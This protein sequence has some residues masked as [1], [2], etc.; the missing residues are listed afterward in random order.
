[1]RNAYVLALGM[2]AGCGSC[3]CSGGGSGTDA[4]L[5]CGEIEV[6]AGE[7]TYY[8]ADGS[9]NC[10]FEASPGDLMVA[11]MN[12]ADYDG[13]AVC[14]QCVAV[15]GPNGSVTVRITDQCPGCEAG[16][17]DLSREAFQRIA[18]LSAGR[19]AI[20]WRPVACDVSG[21]IRYRFKDGS[22]AFWVAIQIRNHRHAVKTVEARLEDGTWRSINRASYNYFVD[23]KGLGEGPYTLRVT[24]VHGL[25]VEDANIPLGDATE[26]AGA[27]QLPVCQ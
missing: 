9:G 27:A 26:V 4:P 7:A 12:A 2:M 11:A 13:S 17:I 21:P 20:T 5:P 24:D 19:V 16:D 3:S 18:A 14:G 15:D 8:D 23:P 1:M 22:N 6:H 25:T 10:S